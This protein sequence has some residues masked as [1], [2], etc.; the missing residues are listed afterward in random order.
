MMQ[1]WYQ[2]IIQAKQRGPKGRAAKLVSEIWRLWDISPDFQNK[3]RRRPWVQNFCQ[4][5]TSWRRRA[6]AQQQR[7]ASLEPQASL[8]SFSEQISASAVVQNIC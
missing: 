6:A 3:F 1:Y 5:I 4:Y 7:L 2:N 8:P